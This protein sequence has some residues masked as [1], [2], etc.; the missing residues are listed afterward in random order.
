MKIIKNDL[1]ELYNSLK[2]IVSKSLMSRLGI[3]LL[4]NNMRRFTQSKG[5]DDNGNE[6]DWKPYKPNSVMYVLKTDRAGRPGQ[7]IWKLRYSWYVRNPGKRVK[8]TQYKQYRYGPAG[9]LKSQLLK[10]T[11]ALRMSVGSRFGKGNIFRVGEAF[12]EFG[13]N[14]KYAA[15]QHYK[16]GRP[17]VGISNKDLKQITAI[18]ADEIEKKIR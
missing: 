4:A 14:L 9:R 12:V 10:D 15:Y 3:Q 1:P 11:G 2:K 5:V 7:V 8:N 13:S 18:I 17:I 6:R 16:L